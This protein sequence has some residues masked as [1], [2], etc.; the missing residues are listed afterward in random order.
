M[1]LMRNGVIVSLTLLAILAACGGEE[2]VASRGIAAGKGGTAA[3]KGAAAGAGDA[4]A[5]PN[6]SSSL[7]EYRDEAF[8]ESEANRDPFRDYTTI[9]RATAVATP[10]RA[11]IMPTTGVDQMKLIA[12]ISGVARP[13]AMLQDGRGVGH[14][15]ERGDYIG[16]PEVV[17]TGGVEGM[18]VSLNWRVDKI[19]PNE[20]VLARED[21]TA[22]NRPAITRIVPL[23]DPA[24]LEQQQAAEEAG[25]D[26]EE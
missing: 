24:E 9:F 6:A 15:V 5:G 10:Q 2:K 11:V 21:P 18:P 23:Y 16:R 17:Q 8:V 19:R 12:I 13:M 26:S 7:L 20:L 22:A 1:I 4:A 14:T 25:S 3:A